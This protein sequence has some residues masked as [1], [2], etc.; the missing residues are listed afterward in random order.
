MWRS[1]SDDEHVHYVTRCPVAG[2]SSRLHEPRDS[3]QSQ[4]LSSK[5]I[6]LPSTSSSAGLSPPNMDLMFASDGKSEN[7]SQCDGRNFLR[8]RAKDEKDLAVQLV[9]SLLIGV[10]AFIAFSVRFK[11][12]LRYSRN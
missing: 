4:A 10:S 2:A 1:V 8:P 11:K 5:S 3:R 7:K 6:E 9:L 12:L